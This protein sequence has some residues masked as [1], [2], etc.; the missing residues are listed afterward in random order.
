MTDLNRIQKNVLHICTKYPEAVDDRS[1]LLEKYW[2]EFDGWSE[3]RSLYDNL[4]YSTRPET[5]TRRLR[6][7][8]EMGLVQHSQ[9]VADQNIKAME[10]EKMRVKYNHAPKA[11]SWL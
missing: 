9:E 3:Y 11:I 2:L 4:K 6:E 5:I 1:M 8:R 7:I 10:N